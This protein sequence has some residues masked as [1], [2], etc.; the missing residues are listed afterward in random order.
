MQDVLKRCGG[1]GEKKEYLALLSF[2]LLGKRAYYFAEVRR[3]IGTVKEVYFD[4]YFS[5]HSLLLYS[6]I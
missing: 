4:A 2:F 5:S 3:W 6:D 1:V